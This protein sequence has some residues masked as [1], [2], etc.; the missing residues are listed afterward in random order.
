MA[1]REE[2]FAQRVHD[3]LTQLVS[4]SRDSKQR[5][6]SHSFTP[7]S[8]QRRQFVHELCTHFGCDSAAYDAE[9]YR[10]I[11]ATAFKDKVTI[12]CY[13]PT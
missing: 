5:T 12:L 4:L 13:Y 7:M 6:R 11:V 2:N 10:N 3:Q 1:V 9:P 8:R